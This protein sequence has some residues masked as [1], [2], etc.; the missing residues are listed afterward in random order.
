MAF[1]HRADAI[2]A[3][4]Q[5]YRMVSREEEV[6]YQVREWFPCYDL[7]YDYIHCESDEQ[8]IFRVL[9]KGVEY[10]ATLGDVQCTQA[11][12]NMNVVQKVKVI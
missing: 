4:S 12:K 3:K 8:L 10:L 7:K 9:S 6:L 1:R 11:F 2:K 5:N